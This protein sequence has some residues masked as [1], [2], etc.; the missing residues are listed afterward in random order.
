MS[1]IVIASI[2]ATIVAVVVIWRLGVLAHR[3]MLL[4]HLDA[5]KDGFDEK[6]EKNRL[7]EAPGNQQPVAV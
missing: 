1:V 7:Y 5:A 3:Q 4:A 2:L 6:S